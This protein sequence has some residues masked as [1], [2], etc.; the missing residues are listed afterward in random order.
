MRPAVF[1]DRDGVL[2]RPEFRNGRSYAPRRLED[3]VLYDDA[4]PSVATLK[5]AGLLV[6]VVTN[7]PDVGAGLVPQTVIEEMHRRLHAQTAIDDVEVSFET[8]AEGGRRRKPAPGMLM[9]AAEKW[10]ID[11]KASFMVGDRASDVEAGLRAGCRSIFID[12]GYT[13][14]KPPNGQIA[15]VD[16]L[17][18]A[19]A[20]ILAAHGR[21]AAPVSATKVD[22]D[23]AL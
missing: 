18:A 17:A 23:A 7:Q 19:T 6:I 14:E 13:A 2:A 15:T 4:A 22:N 11:L 12:H 1:L 5:A 9:D 16:S 8:S 10:E 3:F 20:V 21:Q